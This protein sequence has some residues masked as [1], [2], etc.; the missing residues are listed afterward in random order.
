MERLARNTESRPDS[1]DRRRLHLQR[2]TAEGTAVSA[3]PWPWSPT[4][5]RRARRRLCEA[6]YAKTNE[7]LD[8]GSWRIAAGCVAG[9]AASWRK[10]RATAPWS[11]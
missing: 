2:M 9:V 4:R 8:L 6:E 1:V 11:S 3:K 5:R 10:V 7:D